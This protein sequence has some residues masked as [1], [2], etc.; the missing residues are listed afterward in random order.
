MVLSKRKTDNKTQ[1]IDA[2]GEEFFKK[3]TNN[4]VLTDQHIAKIIEM[5]DAKAEVEY[6]ATNIDNARIAENDYSLSVSSDVEVKDT[7][8]KVDIVVLNREIAETVEKI[9][10]LRRDIDAIVKEIEA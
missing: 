1:F 10:A 3:E 9:S 7:R 6:V 2:S 8:E 4:N 5:F